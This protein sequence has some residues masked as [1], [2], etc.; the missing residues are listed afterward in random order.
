M[1]RPPDNASLEDGAK[2]IRANMPDAGLG[3]EYKSGEPELLAKAYGDLLIDYV[4]ICGG[5]VCQQQLA[6]ACKRAVQGTTTTESIAFSKAVAFMLSHCR[7][8]S[9]SLSSG[10]KT[11]PYVARVCK[12]LALLQ[13]APTGPQ[14]AH[15][16][17]H[18][19]QRSNHP[20]NKN[21]VGRQ[22]LKHRPAKL[23]SPAAQA[24]TTENRQLHISS[25][26]SAML[27]LPE[28]LSPSRR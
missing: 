6:Q 7:T 12:Q 15:R 16:R 17:R 13:N 14:P 18:P 23:P 27:L 9:K 5:G 4:K 21:A 22:P 25:P 24:A 19:A 26:S 8:K 3:E 10:L 11:G 2:V 28:L 20:A 1:P